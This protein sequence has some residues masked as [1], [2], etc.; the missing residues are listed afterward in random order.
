LFALEQE[1]EYCPS[2]RAV[3]LLLSASTFCL[4]LFFLSLPRD[5]QAKP[6]ETWLTELD[7]FT[8]FSKEQRDAATAAL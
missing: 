5:V 7:E 1:A 3:R 8:K 6:A 2:R 4:P